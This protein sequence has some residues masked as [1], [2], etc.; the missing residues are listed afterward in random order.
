MLYSPFLSIPVFDLS[1]IFSHKMCGTEGYS[2]AVCWPL[3]E[4]LRL[5]PRVE[6]EQGDSAGA[7]CG[8]QKVWGAVCPS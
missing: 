4:P 6:R 8:G 7:V 1:V 5:E 2:K 3:A